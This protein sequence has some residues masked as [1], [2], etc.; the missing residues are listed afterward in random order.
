[1][2]NNSRMNFIELITRYEIEIPMLQRDYAY[3]RANE[4]EKRKNFL[5]NLKNYLKNGGHELDFIYGTVNGDKLIL[6]DGQQRITTLF[7]LNWY[8]ALKSGNYEDFKEKIS[9]NGKSKFSYNTRNSSKDFCDYLIEKRDT[10]FDNSE[11]DNSLSA[12]IKDDKDFLH[13][14]SW[15]PT[16]DSMLNMIDDIHKTFED[17]D[18]EAYSNLNKLT[19]NFLNLADYKLTDD[20]YVKMNSRGKP[21]T[22]FEN[23]KSKWLKLCDELDK[24]ENVDKKTKIGLGKDNSLRSYV[25]KKLDQD[26]LDAFWSLKQEDI[27]KLK[28]YE[29]FDTDI[30]DNMMLNFISVL[31]INYRILEKLDGEEAKEI[32]ALMND[33][34]K[35][36][37]NTISYSKLLD[38]LNDDNGEFT[39]ELIKCFDAFCENGKWN[40]FTEDIPTFN[41]KDIIDTILDD[42]NKDMEYEKKVKFFA[43][44]KCLLIDN[45]DNVRVNRWMRFA[46]NVISNSYFIANSVN[47]Y[48]N[49]IAAINDMFDKNIIEKSSSDEIENYPSIDNLQINEELIKIELSKD[50]EWAD[51]L[52]LAENELQ[53]FEGRLRYPLI[54]CANEKIDNFKT[55]LEKLRLIFGKKG[56][57]CEKEL[58]MAVLSKG[59]YTLGYKSNQSLLKN[60]ARDNSWRRFLKEKQETEVPDT[61][62]KRDYFKQVID[63][64][65]KDPNFDSSNVKK[66]LKQIASAYKPK[67]KDWRWYLIQLLND[68]KFGEDFSFGNDRCIRFR[69]DE[70]DLLPGTAITGYHSELYTLYYYCQLKDK[71]FEVKYHLTKTEGE[72][73][74][75]EFKD[76]YKITCEDRNYFK[77]SDNNG[78]E[79]ESKVNFDNLE[80]ELENL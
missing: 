20:L 28:D 34:S 31:A 65:I 35:E 45:K 32:S 7:L 9:K 43:L 63:D 3:G 75:I 39:F 73:P 47:T 1:M 8:L 71:G 38:I 72:R 52:I 80:S 16:I 50:K 22:R 67:E 49:G 12:C 70:I 54:D 76:S 55:Y 17:V 77:I 36:L 10:I 69:D 57:T 30:I 78:N 37:G 60:D 40:Y 51:L 66:S 68:F 53:Y 4:S 26:W 6:L 41:E 79:K 14:W 61:D 21:L 29:E 42:H 46:C 27:K 15:D 44:T 19:F 58:I 59:D 23:L 64:L 33:K 25:A 24:P 2:S 5:E 48:I 18:S 11:N 62:D 74:Y 13:H 56:C